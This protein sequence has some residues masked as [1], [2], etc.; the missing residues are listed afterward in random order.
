VFVFLAVPA[1]P[2]NPENDWLDYTNAALAGIGGLA[3]I[4]AIFIALRAQ[5]TA[6]EAIAHERRRQFELE[7]LRALLDDLDSTSIGVESYDD[8]RTLRRYEHRLSLLPGAE[9]SFWR[10]VMD[11]RDSDAVIAVLDQAGVYAPLLDEHRR[12]QDEAD[13]LQLEWAILVQQAAEVEAWLSPV[14]SKHS[15]RKRDEL[16]ERSKTDKLVKAK[17]RQL[18]RE[19]RNGT[20]ARLVDDVQQAIK[21]RVDGSTTVKTQSWMQ[22]WR[23]WFDRAKSGPGR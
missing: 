19:Y 6:D 17:L 9:L 13:T 23:R 14:F 18:Q 8:P 21:S 3:G 2:V 4:V 5:R 10:A 12:R 1:I 16:R 15:A 7:I 20:A 11:A 22:P